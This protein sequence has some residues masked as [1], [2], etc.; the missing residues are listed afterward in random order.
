MVSVRTS[1][2]EVV[3]VGVG[4]VILARVLTLLGALRYGSSVTDA[5]VRIRS[6]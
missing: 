4:D 3:G 1:V 2:V 6:R 5:R